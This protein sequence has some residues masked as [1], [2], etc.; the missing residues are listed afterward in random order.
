MLKMIEGRRL[1]AEMRDCEISKEMSSLYFKLAVFCLFKARVLDKQPLPPTNVD[2][3]VYTVFLTV[4]QI[5]RLFELAVYIKS[6]IQ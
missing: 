2:C 6:K 4:L 3:T 1:E 5:L